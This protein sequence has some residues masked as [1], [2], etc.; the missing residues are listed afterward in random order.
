MPKFSADGIDLY[1]RPFEEGDV[2]KIT[3]DLRDSDVIEV[4]AM[5]GP[6]K[7]TQEHIKT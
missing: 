1:V 7:T 5:M 3:P 2:E 4:A 6:H